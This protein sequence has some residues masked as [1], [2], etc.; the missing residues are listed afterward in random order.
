MSLLC[1]GVVPKSGDAKECFGPVSLPAE[2]KHH[3]C[4]PPIL[5]SFRLEKTLKIT[6]SNC[7][8]AI[9]L[10]Y[11]PTQA[12]AFQNAVFAQVVNS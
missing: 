2:E 5:E 4:T 10:M 3:R 11:A 1:F 7:K 9:L 8:I 6:E 12:G